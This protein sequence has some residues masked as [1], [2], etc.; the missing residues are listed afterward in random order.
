MFVERRHDLV[1]A[2]LAFRSKASAGIIERLLHDHLLA[3]PMVLERPLVLRRPLIECPF[4][5][6]A[7]GHS[8][9]VVINGRV[10]VGAAAKDLLH[11]FPLI[12]CSL[13]LLA[14]ATIS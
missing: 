3:S 1:L 14:F 4:Y 5:R 10:L 9:T 13:L 12:L 11:H 7:L 8:F 2:F 6:G